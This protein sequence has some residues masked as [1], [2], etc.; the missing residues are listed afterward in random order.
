MFVSPPSG[1]ILP[2]DV[3]ESIFIEISL[4]FNESMF[5]SREI[6]FCLL[7]KG[8]SECKLDSFLELLSLFN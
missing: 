6:V 4:N 7:F 8:Y 1:K 2:K 3:C 5:E